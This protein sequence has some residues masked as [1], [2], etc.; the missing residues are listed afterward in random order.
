MHSPSSSTCASA[1]SSRAIATLTLLVALLALGLGL[2]LRLAALGREGFWLDEVFSASF[3][4]LSFPGTVLAVLLLDF[5]PPLYYLQL[6]AW[7]RLGHGDIWL[8]LNSVLW[9]TGA[10]LG[11]YFGTRRQYGSCAGALA[12]LVCAVLGGEIYFAHELRMYPMAS[13]LIV[14][15]WIAADRLARDYRF[16]SALPLIVLLALLGAIHSA[17]VIAA[18]AALLYVMPSGSWQQVRKALPTWLGVCAVVVC[19]Y[20]PW[21]ANAGS[22]PGIT[23]ASPPSIAALIQTVGGWLIGYGGAPLP[24]WVSTGAAILVAVGLLAALL[25]TPRLSRLVVCFLVWPLL[26]GAILCVIVQPIWLDRTFAFCAPFVAIAFGAA[27]G[28]RLEAAGSTPGR[29]LTYSILGLS[30]ALVFASAALAY[31]QVTTPNKPDH[32]RDLAEYLAAQTRSG[33]LIYIPRDIDFWGV[34]RYLVG[35]DWGSALEVQDIAVMDARKRW[36]RLYGW[37]GQAKLERLGAMPQSRRL[38]RYRIPIFTG[39]SPLPELPAVSGEWLVSVDG[40]PLSAPQESRLCTGQYPAPIKFG[41][42][43]LYHWPCH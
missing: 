25:A 13:C 15:S 31:V 12:L 41:R 35:P 29:S 9:S 23:H 2:G 36:R 1:D 40:E 6:N 26:F 4:E 7:G 27:L 39:P 21:L 19:T 22:R 3:A 11:V 8:L 5:H 37:L 17:S 18:S 14:L 10:M 30:G 28:A 43:E 34:N 16:V 20:L 33:E 24:S 32:Y 42:L 38:D